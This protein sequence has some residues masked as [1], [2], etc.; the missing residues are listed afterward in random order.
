MHDF[1]IVA[2]L[3]PNV[4]KAGSRHDLEIAL[5]R[6]AQWVHSELVQHLDDTDSTRHSPMFPVHPDSKASIETH[7]ART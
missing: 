2:I 1:I 7:R 6:D 5:D 3:D 4:T